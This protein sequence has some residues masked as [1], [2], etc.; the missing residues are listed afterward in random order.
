MSID[1][2]G[3]KGSVSTVVRT[4]L[5]RKAARDAARIKSKKVVIRRFSAREFT[6]STSGWVVVPVTKKQLFHTA[7]Y[8]IQLPPAE[9][10]TASGAFYETGV[11]F[12]IFIV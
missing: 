8:A 9:P 3:V 11:S 10:L 4:N 5:Y 6:E 1:R 12:S 7:H 2:I